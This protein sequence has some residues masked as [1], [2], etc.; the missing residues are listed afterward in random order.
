MAVMN[1]RPATTA[2]QANTKWP[3]NFCNCFSVTFSFW[4]TAFSNSRHILTLSSGRMEHWRGMW[5]VMPTNLRTCVAPCVLSSAIGTPVDLKKVRKVFKSPAHLSS[6]WAMNRKSSRTCRQ[7]WT[8]NCVSAM[9]CK[10]VLNRSN[11]A[12]DDPA[13]IGSVLA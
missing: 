3:A 8:F 4:L 11:M 7:W 5:R 10:A 6:P 9:N 1:G 2:L 13:P 12:Q